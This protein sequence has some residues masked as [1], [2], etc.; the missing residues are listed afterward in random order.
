MLSFDVNIDVT[1]T[2]LYWKAETGFE[3]LA[4]TKKK[5]KKIPTTHWADTRHFSNMKRHR[6]LV[7]SDT[8]HPL[9]TVSDN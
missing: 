3:S 4:V 9:I 5:N 1:D 6:L 7:Y 8:V 2:D